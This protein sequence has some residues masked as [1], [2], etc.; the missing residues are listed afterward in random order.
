MHDGH[1]GWDDSSYGRTLGPRKTFWYAIDFDWKDGEWE[2]I[3]M[4][5]L[6]STLAMLDMHNRD[7]ISIGSNHIFLDVLLE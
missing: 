5:D 2:Y 7:M 1:M 3:M 6:P 4:A